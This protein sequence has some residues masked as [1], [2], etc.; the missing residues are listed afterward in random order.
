ME[1]LKQQIVDRTKELGLHVCGF[2]SAEL[3]NE[4][5]PEGF[6]PE[7][8]LKDSQSVIMFGIRMPTGSLEPG[9]PP[10]WAR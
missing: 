9:S 7:S 2:A 1:H 6:G 10:Q 3:A 5:A 4:K 8:H